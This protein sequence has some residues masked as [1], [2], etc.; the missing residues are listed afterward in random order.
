MKWFV[1]E[2]S[3]CPQSRKTTCGPV[4]STL[5]TSCMMGPV[6]S[7]STEEGGRERCEPQTHRGPQRA[8]QLEGLGSYWRLG[9]L[10]GRKGE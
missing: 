10:K 7:N 2:D 3:P 4:S 6:L 9:P 8:R 1:K 5:T